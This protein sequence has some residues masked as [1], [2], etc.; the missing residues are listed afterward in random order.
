[1]TYDILAQKGGAQLYSR[2]AP[3]YSE[4]TGHDGVPTQ[5]LR[6]TFEA[7][8]QELDTHASTF[9]SLVTGPL[10]TVNQQAAGLKLEGVLVPTSV[11]KH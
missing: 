9:D 8:V 3:I 11:E 1:V 4:L 6:S 2:M 10:A 5:G 7:Q